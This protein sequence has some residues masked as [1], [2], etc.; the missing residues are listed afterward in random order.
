MALETKEL[1]SSVTQNPKERVE[2]VTVAPKTIDG[3]Q[4]TIAP[5]TPMVYAATGWTVWQ[6]AD[7][8]TLH[9]FMWPDQHVAHATDES[10]ANILIRGKIHY[11]DVVLPASQTQATLDTALQTTCRD[12]GID[13]QGLVNVR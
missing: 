7:A 2:A 13:V 1:F 10:I 9:G 12:L 11:D 5:L 4:G 3:G 6:D 8:N